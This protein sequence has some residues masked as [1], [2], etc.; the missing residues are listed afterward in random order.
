MPAD[1]RRDTSLFL[2]GLLVAI[3]ILAVHIVEYGNF[4]A[5][6]AGITFA[7]AKNLARG[8]GLVLNPGT[9]PVEGYSNATYTA[10]AVDPEVYTVRVRA[11][12]GCGAGLPSND[13][14]VT[15]Q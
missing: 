5:D 7:Y 4:I 14:V 9:D 1:S 11:R 10:T 6:D 2:A 13:V 12:N 3:A 15:I 8:D